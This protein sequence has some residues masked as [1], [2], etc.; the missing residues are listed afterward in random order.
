[1]EFEWDERKNKI[2]IKKHGVDFRMAVAVFS[3]E[4]R[5]EVYDRKHS[6]L[7]E[8]RFKT[9][10]FV[11][12]LITVFFTERNGRIRII[13]ARPATKEEEI[14]YNNQNDIR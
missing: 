14:G 11:H 6:T 2:N 7:F 12:R 1:M 13:S 5:L 4:K 8:D 10:G 3:D 9:I